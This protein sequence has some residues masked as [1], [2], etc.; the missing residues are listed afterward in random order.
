[1][2]SYAL[3]GIIICSLFMKNSHLR[4]LLILNSYNLT[5]VNL[6]IFK[7]VDE[8]DKRVLTKFKDEFGNKVVLKLS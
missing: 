3:S 8:G 4:D 6:F 7:S 2:S 5:V 1:M